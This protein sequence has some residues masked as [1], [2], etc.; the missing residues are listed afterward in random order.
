MTVTGQF[1][2]ID[3]DEVLLR[4]VF[5]NLFRNAVEAAQGG[6]RAP[7]V[8]GAGRD[9]QAEGACCM[10]VHDNGPGIVP[11]GGATRTVFQPFFTTR[12]SGTGLGL[13]IVLKVM[14]THNGRVAV[15]M[16]PL[17]GASFS[18]RSPVARA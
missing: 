6:G 8:A 18:S 14:V 17:G 16:S 15:A 7:T 12:S 3:G 11:V 9:R 1:G 4:Q 2:T 5:G 13:A 10:A